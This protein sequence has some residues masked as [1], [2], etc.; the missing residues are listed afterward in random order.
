MAQRTSAPTVQK[1]K[2]ILGDDDSGE[3][4][5]I[6]GMVQITNTMDDNL[7]TKTNDQDKEICSYDTIDALP[8]VDHYRNLF[9]ITSPESKFRP[10]LEA[11]HDT[12]NTPSKFRIGSTID[13]NSEMISTFIPP[14]VDV[15]SQGTNNP[16]LDVVKFGW[17]VGVLVSIEE[18]FFV[19]NSLF[20]D[21]M[22]IEYFRCNAL[23]SS[24]LGDWASG[25][26]FSDCYC[27]Y[28]NSSDSFNSLINECNL[29]QWRSERWRNILSHFSQFG[30]GIWWCYWT[31]IFLR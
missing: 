6:S 25:H 28:I 22:C 14:Q 15:P 1:V 27:S 10:T 3:T 16:K 19:M 9:S 11:L 26:W 23:S 7:T 4:S 5:S 17:I 21:S 12:S 29:Y 8:H 13:L 18:I 20:V 24:I 31:D 30:T 2:I